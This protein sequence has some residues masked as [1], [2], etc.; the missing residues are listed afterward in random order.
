MFFRGLFLAIF[1]TALS[2]AIVI[3]LAAGLWKKGPTAGDA[4]TEAIIHMGRAAMILNIA[5]AIVETLA[6]GLIV[7]FVALA[8]VSIVG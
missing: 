6:V 8:V 5:A 1:V 3:L 4:R 2:G 7:A